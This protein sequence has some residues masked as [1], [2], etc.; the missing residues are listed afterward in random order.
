MRILLVSDLHYRLRQFDWLLAAA[1]SVDALMIAGDLLD[2]RSPVTLDVQAVAVAAALRALAGETAV[3]AASGNHDLDGRDAAG[4]KAARWMAPLAACG[5]HGDSTSALLG[6]DL[7]TVCPWWD[8]P[9][10]RAALDGV[11]AAAAD[12]LRRRWIWVHHAPPAGSPLAWDGR[13]SWGDDVLSGW[14]ARY[15]PD[16]VLTGHVHQAPFAP[17]GGWADRVG[18]TWVFNAGQQPGPVP[19]NVV[20]DLDAG[21][22]VWTSAE[23]R[24]SVEFS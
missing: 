1:P 22:A 21:T 19:A 20:L 3:F 10:A 12:R 17:G 13:R 8:G 5:V 15:A 24:S 4:E 23:G 6:D 18:S 2:I 9:Q 14:I 16:L 7:V 11:L